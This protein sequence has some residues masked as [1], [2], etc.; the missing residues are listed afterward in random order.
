MVAMNIPGRRHVSLLVHL[1]A[2]KGLKKNTR[3]DLIGVM[4]QFY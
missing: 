1:D 2:G 3:T 4:M